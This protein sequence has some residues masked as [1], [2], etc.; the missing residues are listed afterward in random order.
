M[1]ACFADFRRWYE[2]PE[3]REKTVIMYLTKRKFRKVL[4]FNLL[5]ALLAT[6]ACD[7]APTGTD[8]TSKEDIRLKFRF[9]NNCQPIKLLID[10][11]LGKE[12]RVNL[13]E[14]ELRNFIESRLRSARIP[15]E[16]NESGK[17]TR[18]ADHLYA[19]VNIVGISFT[20]KLEFNKVLEDPLS[21]T[22]GTAMTWET[23]TFGHF[24]FSDSVEENKALILSGFQNH[25]DE[26]ITE[27]L[28][29]NQKYCE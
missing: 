13:T 6:V 3:H 21:S 14:T 22:Y 12:N 1:N 18:I 29:A 2:V 27:Y 11:S 4:I 15:I 16:L 28:R 7:P 25:L 20:K 19:G 5:F 24:G 8:T 17:S 23:G 9:F 10:V 26:F